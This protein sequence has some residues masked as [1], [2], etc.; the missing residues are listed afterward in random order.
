MESFI[1]TTNGLFY[2]S[3]QLHQATFYS[4]DA[5]RRQTSETNANQ[6]VTKYGYDAASHLLTLTDGKNQT[7]LW[8]YNHLRPG[9]Q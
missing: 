7:N 5:A 1:Y 6:E 8:N 9:D 3:N 2:Y 4:Y